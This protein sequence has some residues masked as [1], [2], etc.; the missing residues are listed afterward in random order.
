MD[1]RGASVFLDFDGTVTSYD[2]GVHLLERL[3]PGRWTHIEERYLSGEIGSRECMAAQWELVPRNRELIESV[4]REVPLDPGLPSLL[5]FLRSVD[6]E[7]TIVSDGYGFFAQE[8][9]EEAG[10]R[11]LTNVIDWDSFEIV[12]PN[13]DDSCPCAVCWTCKQAP[14]RAAQES[15][16]RTVLIGDGTSDAKAAQVADVVFAKDHLAKWCQQVGIAYWAFADLTDLA[17]QLTASIPQG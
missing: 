2:T 11:V 17:A 12:F 3:A 1:L 8:V 14:I 9:G 16:R 5:A 10:L 6:A 15:G 4:T 7:V 13:R